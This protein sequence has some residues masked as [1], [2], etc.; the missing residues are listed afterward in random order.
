MT[1]IYL[2]TFQVLMLQDRMFRQSLNPQW[3]QITSL[4][5]VP[6]ITITSQLV[7]TPWISF[8]TRC[9]T[10]HRTQ[11][12]YSRW[13][14]C[15]WP[16]WQPAHKIKISTGRCLKCLRLHRCNRLRQCRTSIRCIKDWEEA[17]GRINHK[18]DRQQRT[19]NRRCL[20]FL[21][22]RVQLCQQV[23]SCFFNSR[24]SLRICSVRFKD[25]K[26]RRWGSHLNLHQ[27]WNHQKSF[28]LL[29]PSSFLWIL[30]YSHQQCQ[31]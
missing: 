27:W 26:A 8:S 25:F 2:Q 31:I 19:L 21:N 23:N 3:F 6:W 30:L 12:F 1:L 18:S 13:P 17:Q 15:K 28:N 16:I 14:W 9:L 10:Y 20:R 22:K 5:T 24:K 11:L 7:L 4:H 29:R